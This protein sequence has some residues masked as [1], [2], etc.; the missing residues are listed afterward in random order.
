PEENRLGR[1][2]RHPRRIHER[3]FARSS[4]VRGFPGA[5]RTSNHHASIRGLQLLFPFRL[6]Q[7]RSESPVATV[8]HGRRED[9]FKDNDDLKWKRP[10]LDGLPFARLINIR[11]IIPLPLA[12]Q[13]F[14]PPVRLGS[15]RNRHMLPVRIRLT[16]TEG[17]LKGQEYDFYDSA[18]WVLG[19]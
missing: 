17:V 9:Q 16:I 4:C 6:E 12:R 2:R 13:S 11:G 15:E 18:R 3:G 7:A 5:V 1:Q 8:A 19:R 10:R 14:Y